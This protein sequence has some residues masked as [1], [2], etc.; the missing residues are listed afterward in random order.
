M[1]ANPV[2]CR[3]NAELQTKRTYG[4]GYIESHN[5]ATPDFP[6]LA[7]EVKEILQSRRLM[8]VMQELWDGPLQVLEGQIKVRGRPIKFTKLLA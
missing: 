4:F 2:S 5:Y 6:S 7:K 1:G 8:I 3:A